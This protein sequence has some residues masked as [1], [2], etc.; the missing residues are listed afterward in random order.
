M[1]DQNKITYKDAGV[2]TEKGQEFVKRIKANVASTHNKNV[3]GGL[4]GFA[5]CYDVSFLKSYQEPIL[6]SGTDGV[7]TKLQIA[8][9]LGIHN[10]VGIDLVAMCVNDILV[11]GGKPIFF[12]DY[13]ACGKLH[14]PTMEAIVSGIVKGCSLA[15]CSLVGGETAEHPGVMPDDEYDLA[16]FVVGVVEKG[17]MIDGKTIS[18]GD[19]IIGLKSSG[20]HSNGFSLIRKLLLK[21]GKLPTSQEQIDFI[22]DHIFVPTNIYVKSILS[23]IDKISIK[24]MVHITGGGF[25]ENIPRVLPEGVGAEIFSLPESY[26]FSKLEKDHSLDR[27]DMY[28]TFNMGIGYILVVDSSLVDATMNELHV[29]GEDSFVIGKTNDSGKISITL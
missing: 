1:S 10:T 18:P 19:T 26:V 2:D 16:G 24:G 22:K 11:N 9:Q 20:P 25:Y 12:Q 27:N 8:R 14:L 5:A 23:L 28:G 3:L 21:D 6:L 29:L 17:K 7:G 13:I 15:D 4:G